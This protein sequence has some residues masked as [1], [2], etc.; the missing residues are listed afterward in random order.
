MT[1]SGLVLPLLGPAALDRRMG[2]I[3]TI[4]SVSTTPLNTDHCAARPS[5]DELILTRP[6]SLELHL[7]L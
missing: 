2:A 3:V 7:T 1:Q 6:T 5:A 4:P